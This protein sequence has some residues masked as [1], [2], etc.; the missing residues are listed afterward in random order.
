[1]KLNVYLNFPGTCE[2]A[3][4][5]YNNV[6]GGEITSMERYAGSPMEDMAPADWQDKILHAS[7]HVADMDL[8]ASDVGPDRFVNPNGYNLSIS[9]DDVDEAER[10][11]GGLTEGGTVVM[12]LEETFWAARFGMLKD[13]YGIDW[14]VNCE[15]AT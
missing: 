10:I 3:F 1:M 8:M 2:E 6:L 7:M 4:T 11:F 13:R 15:A 14:M 9:V 5:F 12:P